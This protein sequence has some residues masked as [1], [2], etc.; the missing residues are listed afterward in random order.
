M[1]QFPVVLQVLPALNSGGVEKNTLE[2]AQAI[3]EK[4]PER[5]HYVASFGG[6]LEKQLSAQHIS[7]PLNSKSPVQIY[8]NID[9]LVQI[10]KTKKIQVI[11]AMSRA[12]AWSAWRAA[13][14]TGIKFITTYHGVYNCSNYLKY[15]YNSVMARGSPVIA[16]S[17]YVFKHIQRE[18]PKLGSQVVLIKS[19]VDTKLFDPVQITQNQIKSLKSRW[20]VPD[21]H[22]LI[23]L[24][25]RLTRWKGQ[26]VFLKAL[27]QIDYLNTTA[28]LLGDAQGRLKY[29][30]ELENLASDLPVKFISSCESMPVAYAAADLVLSCSTEP[31]AFGRVTAEALSMGCAFIGTD[32]GATPEMCIDG[33]TGFLVPPNQPDALACQIEQSFHGNLKN[34]AR[35]H[36]QKNFSLA[37]S[38]GKILDLY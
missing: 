5:A 17:E 14:L 1:A 9:R 32:L 8:K 29:Q 7:L 30:Q 25:G 26:A 10:I 28:V 3:S 16:V 35:E 12:P 6:L 31:E 15:L 2:I 19:G 27:R 36:I 4:H 37:D 22:R 23:L 33:Q 13:E 21:A 24:P 11:H 20:G 18:Y 38:L 34:K